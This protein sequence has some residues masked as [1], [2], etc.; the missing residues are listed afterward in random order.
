[1]KKILLATTLLLLLVTLSGSVD[2]RCFTCEQGSNAPV[3][4][5]IPWWGIFEQGYSGCIQKH[6]CLP[7][8]VCIDTCELIGNQC[9][10][11]DWV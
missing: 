10:Y 5:N 3:C 6:T 11:W 7:S 8:G 1:M 9:T 2:A 4:T